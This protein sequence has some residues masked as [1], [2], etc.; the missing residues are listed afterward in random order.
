MD[1]VLVEQYVTVGED[2]DESED[3]QNDENHVFSWTAEM[4][5]ISQTGTA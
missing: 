5:W 3:G 1:Y 4:R 2:P